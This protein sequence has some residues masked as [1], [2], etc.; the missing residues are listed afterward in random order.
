MPDSEPRT[1]TATC[2]SRYDVILKGG[3]LIDPKT[4]TSSIRDVAVA[5]GRIAAVCDNIPS[6][7]G[8]QVVDVSGLY[9][10]PG[11]IDMHVHVYPRFFLSV[12]ADAH[13]LSNAVTTV[14]DAGSAGSANFADFRQNVVDRSLTRVLAFLHIVDTGMTDI[15]A[16]QNVA[17]MDPKVA[18]RTAETNSDVVVGIKTAHYW[19]YQEWDSDH[20]PW[21][22]VERAVEAGS[23]C[24]LP[25]M[26]DVW[27]RPERTWRDL[28]MSKLRPGDIHTHVFAQQF[29]VILNSKE[30]N[31]LLQDARDRGVRFDLGHGGASFWFRNAVP[32]AEQGFL[33]D[34]IST[35]LHTGSVRGLA[36]NLLHTMSKFLNF[37]A[38]LEDVIARVT[39]A[40][41][42]ILN[43]PEIGSLDIGAFA[44][45]AVLRLHEG[46]FGFI[47]CGGARIQGTKKLECVLT[48]REG[49]LV[50]DPGGLTM[51]EWRDAPPSYWSYKPAG[52]AYRQYG[53]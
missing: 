1:A 48:L 4:N 10:T 42:R 11:L 12:V 49:Q 17:N 30:I 16:E 18:A 24:G 33:P 44:D 20:P 40:P 39:A 19:T 37:G 35:D 32:A 7:L 22:S 34:V 26:A 15:A 2:M 41:A 3:H 14:V 9:V 8:E 36:G 43:R 47:D 46:E 6:S 21:A 29:P 23:L 50:Y 51:P 27:P 28:L 53:K 38:S 25:V 52:P 13:S 5:G 45:I 31:P